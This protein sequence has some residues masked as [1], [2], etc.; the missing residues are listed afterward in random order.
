MTKGAVV[1]SLTIIVG[2]FVIF[3]QSLR[4]DY[5]LA[6]RAVCT[7]NLSAIGK[8]IGLYMNENHDR[9]P[10]LNVHATYDPAD[11]AVPSAQTQT[12]EAFGTGTWESTLGTNPMQNAWLLIAEDMVQGDRFICLAD[13][14]HEART[15]T[16]DSP[17]NY[18]WVSPFNYSYGMH[19]PYA[20][21]GNTAP[22]NSETPGGLVI[23]A[24]QIPY[25][26]NRYHIVSRRNGPSLRP[27]NH[28]G[29]GT[30]FLTFVGSVSTVD[31][32]DS[33]CG[34][35]GDEIYANASEIVGG[36]PETEI[37]TS[38]AKSGRY[39]STTP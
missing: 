29:L 27:S 3:H 12:D 31:S 26:D 13:T 23:F 22:L 32:T 35:D 4:P 25:D 21:A 11:V 10:L 24:D 5:N 1:L 39:E 9:P 28:P 15:Q 30:M 20:T 37:D 8:A 33:Q 17:A 14:A 34:I 38:I 16:V 19:V 18:G 6:K 2:L 7:S 36:I